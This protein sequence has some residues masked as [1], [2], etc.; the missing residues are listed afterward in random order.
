MQDFN[1]SEIWLV[2]KIKNL[3]ISPCWHHDKDTVRATTGQTS[4]D[5]KVT[6]FF[7]LFLCTVFGLIG[8]VKDFQNSKL[9]NLEILGDKRSLKIPLR[10]VGCQRF[11]TT[12][13]DDLQLGCS[14]GCFVR[15]TVEQCFELTP[16]RRCNRISWDS[17]RNWTKTFWL[18]PCTRF[19]VL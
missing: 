19:P 2:Y 16:C 3:V 4:I 10:K 6:I 9:F 17:L 15:T 18:S 1:L 7:Y 11:S 12:H 13:D 8:R 14:D 5:L